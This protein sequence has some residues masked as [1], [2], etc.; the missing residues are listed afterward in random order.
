MTRRIALLLATLA[1]PAV[2]DNPAPGN[3]KILG[4]SN[5]ALRLELFSDFT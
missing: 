4:N 3:G 5:A 2:A 1:L